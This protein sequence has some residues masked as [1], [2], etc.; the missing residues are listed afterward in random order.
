LDNKVFNDLLYSR[1]LL[2]NKKWKKI[3]VV[4]CRRHR[5]HHHHHHYHHQ[6]EALQ[7]DAAVRSVPVAKKNSRC[8]AYRAD[9]IYMT[10]FAS[11]T[12]TYTVG[13]GIQ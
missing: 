5:N 1:V 12:A 13:C 3:S 2:V 9:R 10:T 8:V 11:S 4:Q 6:S 7:R